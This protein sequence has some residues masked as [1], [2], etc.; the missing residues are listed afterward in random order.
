M[1]KFINTKW[2]TGFLIS[3]MVIYKMGRRGPVSNN[4]TLS[5]TIQM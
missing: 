5:K 1:K 2:D 4:P 3:I